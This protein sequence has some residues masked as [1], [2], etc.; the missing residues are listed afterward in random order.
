M[1]FSYQS[2]IFFFPIYFNS[3]VKA[4]D[5]ETDN[6]KTNKTSLFKILNSENVFDMFLSKIDKKLNFHSLF[7][8]KIFSI[9]SEIN[10]IDINDDFEKTLN[11]IE[12]YTF[13]ANLVCDYRYPNF[14]HVVN[15]FNKL[16]EKVEM[17]YIVFKTQLKSYKLQPSLKIEKKFISQAII[18]LLQITMMKYFLIKF[19]N[20]NSSH[21]KRVINK[22]GLKNSIE[23]EEDNYKEEVEDKIMFN[24]DIKGLRFYEFLTCN[25]LLVNHILILFK[26]KKNKENLISSISKIKQFYKIPI[27]TLRG[28]ISTLKKK[29]NVSKISKEEFTTIL[30]DK[31]FIVNLKEIIQ[32]TPM[33]PINEF[34]KNTNIQTENKHDRKKIHFRRKSKLQTENQINKRKKALI[35]EE[36]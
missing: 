23:D 34:S 26:K 35:L 25:H 15:S 22:K 33:K 14:N 8:E 21:Q 10:S 11:M 18:N 5:K 3:F 4:Q 29:L 20:F 36:N 9:W 7:I 31:I 28:H 32:E 16:K 27:S 30:H 6:K 12:Y 1:S 19:D 24:K 17:D 13:L 2:K